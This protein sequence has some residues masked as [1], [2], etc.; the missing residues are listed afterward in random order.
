MSAPDLREKLDE[1]QKLME[2]M[3]QS[4]EEKLRKTEMVH[5]VFHRLG[6][7]KMVDVITRFFFK[8]RQETFEKMGIS[9]ESSGIKLEKTKCFLV[10]LNADPSLNELLVYY[11]KVKNALA[12]NCFQRKVSNFLS[13]LGPF[14]HDVYLN[15][16]FSRKSI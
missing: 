4:W 9:L 15:L 7:I 11:L 10:N 8:K 16:I 12:F 6:R 14:I 3:S 13:L 1:S 2:E 5:K